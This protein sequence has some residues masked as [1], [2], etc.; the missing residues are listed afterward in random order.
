MRAAL[1]ADDT[2]ICLSTAASTH[3]CDK[4]RNLNLDCL[5]HFYESRQHFYSINYT[6]SSD[7]MS[8]QSKS[9]IMKWHIKCLNQRLYYKLGCVI[10]KEPKI[11]KCV[12]LKNNV[13]ILIGLSDDSYQ[14]TLPYNVQYIL[15][16]SIARC[17]PFNICCIQLFSSKMYS[18]KGNW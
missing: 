18:P 10:Q 8:S 13:V 15:L 17:T 11:N 14:Y 16:V 4:K 6:L 12:T 2:L 9:I 5:L 7:I 1:A 3:T